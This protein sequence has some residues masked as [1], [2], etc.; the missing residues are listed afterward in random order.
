MK[1]EL[2]DGNSFGGRLRLAALESRSG[3]GLIKS[4]KPVV[5]GALIIQSL[6]GLLIFKN[7]T[8]SATLNASWSFIVNCDSS[9]QNAVIFSRGRG[10]NLSHIA[11]H[12]QQQH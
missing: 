10:C 9:V 5:V 3:R 11:S 8:H 7:I 1:M 2:I 4:I 12:S 6:S